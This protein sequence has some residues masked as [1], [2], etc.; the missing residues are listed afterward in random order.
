MSAT[1]PLARAIG[2][3]VREPLPSDSEE[4][5]DVEQ[6]YGPDDTHERDATPEEE[7]LAERLV[8]EW[9]GIA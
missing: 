4:G 9:G 1:S 5:Y 8:A 3:T 7:E 2:Q 6:D